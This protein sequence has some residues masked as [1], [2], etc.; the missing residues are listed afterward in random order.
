MNTKKKVKVA[1]RRLAIATDAALVRAGR[2]AEERQHKRAQK[3][4]LKTT[5]KVAGIAATTVAVVVA[6]RAALLARRARAERAEA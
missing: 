3:A 6:A 5:G 4:A 1:A 2:A